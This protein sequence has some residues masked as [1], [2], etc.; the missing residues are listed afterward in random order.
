VLK[1]IR[2]YME[3]A[4]FLA[5]SFAVALLPHRVALSAG[6]WLGR[7][8]FVLLPKRRQIAIDNISDS[9]AFLEKQ[10]GWAGGSPQAIALETFENLGRSVVEVCK[11]Y[12]GR[13]RRLIDAVEFR[14]LEH[15]RQALAKGKGVA[16]ITAHCGNWELLALSFGARYHQVSSVARR[17]DNP[18]LN[19]VTERIRKVYGNG[20]I[21]RTGALRAM[22]AAFKRQEMVGM[23][24]DQAAHPNEG[25][26]VDFL[27]RPAWT[28]R[29]PALIARKSGAALLPVFIHREG[30]T[31][32]VT[33][34]PEYLP[35]QSEDPEVC[36]AEDAAGLT[37]YIEDY[38]IGHPTQWY[39]IH[40]RWKRVPATAPMRSSSDLLVAQEEA[41]VNE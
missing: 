18:H 39:W 21:Y 31:Q 33:I 14:G 28:I 10:P 9:L 41:V 32:I 12:Q 23:L 19:R 38:V 13:G 37:R 17:Q 36:A 6:R 15:Y 16:V 24:I 20:V 40:K 26:L 11:I 2:W 7:L 5:V 8:F 30:D 29:L 27:G 25:I 1:E 35:S 4:L 3:I 34:H 22:F